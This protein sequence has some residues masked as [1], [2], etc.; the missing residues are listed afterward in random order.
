MI[1]NSVLH[2]TL[3]PRLYA[4]ANLY[5]F[6]F[7]ILYNFCTFDVKFEIDLEMSAC[8]GVKERLSIHLSLRKL[9]SSGFLKLLHS[10]QIS[11]L[12]KLLLHV[13]ICLDK[14]LLVLL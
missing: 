14:C 5:G 11:Y 2:L 9:F 13:K 3:F 4:M 6:S 12:D 7:M 8:G 10:Q 1:T